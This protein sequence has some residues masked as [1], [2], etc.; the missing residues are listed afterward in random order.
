MRRFDDI[1]MTGLLTIL[2]FVIAW[3]L[4]ACAQVGAVQG[5]VKCNEHE[6]ASVELRLECKNP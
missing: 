6:N 3:L 5:V 4:T 1:L 2:I